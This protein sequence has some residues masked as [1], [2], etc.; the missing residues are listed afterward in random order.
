LSPEPK[1]M[2]EGIGG[3]KDSTFKKDVYK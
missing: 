2:Q 1:L 3:A